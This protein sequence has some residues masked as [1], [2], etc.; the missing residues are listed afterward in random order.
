MISQFC[1]NNFLHQ[2]HSFIRTNKDKQHEP[3]APNNRGEP[4]C[5]PR[6]RSTS[7]NGRDTKLQI[8]KKR[9][10]KHYIYN[11]NSLLMK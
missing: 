2:K 9:Y 3:H 6:V 7:H 5:S 4:M 10:N 11:L 8:K 1:D